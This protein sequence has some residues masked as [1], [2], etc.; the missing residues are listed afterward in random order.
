MQQ[1]NFVNADGTKSST[2]TAALVGGAA[3]ASIAEI[4]VSNVNKLSLTV[5]VKVAALTA[6]TMFGRTDRLARWMPVL[7]T[8]PTVYGYG[9]TDS[10]TDI[11]TTPAGQAAAIQVDVSYWTDFKIEATSAGAATTSVTASLG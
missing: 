1:Y 7:R 4:D 6:L 11:G 5:D 9:R 3:S 8:D 2:K 10:S